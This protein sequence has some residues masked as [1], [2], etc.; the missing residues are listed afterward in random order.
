MNDDHLMD[1]GEIGAV[2]Q[3]NYCEERIDCNLIFC[4]E[5]CIMKKWRI[6]LQDCIADQVLRVARK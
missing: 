5:Y 2:V 4:C 6:R 3:T 1:S